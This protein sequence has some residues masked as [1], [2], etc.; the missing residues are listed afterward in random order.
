MLQCKHDNDDDDAN[1]K[2]N[3]NTNHDHQSSYNS[4]KEYG[5]DSRW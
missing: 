3:N 2:Y 5:W 1:N 4:I